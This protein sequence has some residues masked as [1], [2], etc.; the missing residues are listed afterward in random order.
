MDWEA[1]YGAAKPADRCDA[2]DA[3]SE[4]AAA[5]PGQLYGAEPYAAGHGSSK[6]PPEPDA[7]V[8]TVKNPRTLA[9]SKLLIRPRYNIYNLLMQV[10]SR[11]A[12]FSLCCRMGARLRLKTEFKVQTVL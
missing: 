11:V 1:I 10:V 6:G 2:A 12:L 7:G 8:H 5:W 4:C 3:S 9:S